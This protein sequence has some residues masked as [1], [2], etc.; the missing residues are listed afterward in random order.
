MIQY[1]AETGHFS[2]RVRNVAAALLNWKA[3]PRVKRGVTVGALRSHIRRSLGL[4][5]LRGRAR[6]EDMERTRDAIESLGIHLCTELN[7]HPLAAS[8]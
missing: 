8:L 5:T 6:E 7:T 4:P 2:L 3:S 1:V